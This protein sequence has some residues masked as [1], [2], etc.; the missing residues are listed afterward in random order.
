MI[1]VPL[2]LN[3]MATKISPRKIIQEHFGQY[4]IGERVYSKRG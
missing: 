4:E 2:K 1:D 3:I